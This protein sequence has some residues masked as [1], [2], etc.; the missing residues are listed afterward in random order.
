MSERGGGRYGSFITS[1]TGSVAHIAE[2]RELAR[3][4]KLAVE[5][6]RG[7]S[8]TSGAISILNFIRG[9]LSML[10]VTATYFG[11]LASLPAA[12]AFPHRGQAPAGGP[13]SELHRRSPFPVALKVC[14]V[15]DSITAG[16]G[17]TGDNLGDA[18]RRYLYDLITQGT[19][20]AN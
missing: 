18:W 7:H 9:L 15:G 4:I 12:W 14:C 1:F 3:S 2:F 8:S 20:T 10:L 19:L 5:N 13:R 6:C 11:L 16:I 17:S